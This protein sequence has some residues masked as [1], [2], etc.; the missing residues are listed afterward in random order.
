MPLALTPS[1]IDVGPTPVQSMLDCP[2]VGSVVKIRKLTVAWSA[3]SSPTPVTGTPFCRVRDQLLRMPDWLLS[4]SSLIINVQVPAAFLPLS[5][6]SGCCG[7]NEPKNDG[8]PEA[9]EVA[10]L[11][12]K[13]V[14]L[15]LA[16]VPVAP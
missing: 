14:L 11:S 16:W 3:V 13:I 1:P 12:S 6:A 5:R 7:W 15:K 8:T 10:A 2:L 9:I 4:R